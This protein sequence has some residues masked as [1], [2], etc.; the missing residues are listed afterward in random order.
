MG[1]P[2]RPSEEFGFGSSG[3]KKLSAEG[4]GGSIGSEAESVAHT[5]VP[6]RAPG[7]QGAVALRLKGDVKREGTICMSLCSLQNILVRVLGVW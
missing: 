3:G 4:A 2:L 5:C 1:A 7:W 6:C